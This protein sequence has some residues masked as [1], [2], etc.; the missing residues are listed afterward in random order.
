MMGGF[1]QVDEFRL[2][3][4]ILE[5]ATCVFWR[6]KWCVLVIMAAQ[7]VTTYFAIAIV[8]VHCIVPRH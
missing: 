2:R 6:V 7:V 1:Y 4:F 5:D 3:E 8:T